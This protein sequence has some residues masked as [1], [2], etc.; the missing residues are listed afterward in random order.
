MT[1]NLD[2]G[3]LAAPDIIEPLDYEQITQQLKQQLISINPQ[4]SNA[5]QL[6][7]EPLTIALQAFAY[8][9]L[10]LRQRVNEAVRSNL[11]AFAS[12]NDLNQ[13]A[14]FY[15]V[16]RQQNEQDDALRIRT[17]N[18]ILGSSTAGGEAHYKY[19][20]LSASAD[21]R[22]VSV[23]S[24]EPGKVR[25]SVLAKSGANINELVE[26]VSNRVTASDVKVLTDTVEVVQSE[27]V[28]INI[29]ADIIPKQGGLPIVIDN[30][31]TT[32]ADVIEQN[33]KLG[34]D[35]SPS[36]LIS[37]I[38]N[39]NINAVQLNQPEANIEIAPNQC[40]DIASIVL[41]LKPGKA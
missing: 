38:H 37:Q 20:A 39:D 10:L 32:L 34:W 6:E 36:W 22:D 13:L 17:K 31:I 23:D 33:R 5:L 19:Q 35:L 21:I 27:L 28:E 4:Y 18:R 14:A 29:N 16:T 1:Q 12:G 11:L 30:L 9:E 26:Q 8:R 15:G 7:S 2:L 3:G 25:V 40:I 24:P 41:N